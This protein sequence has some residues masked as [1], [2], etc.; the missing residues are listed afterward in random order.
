[1]P[2]SVEGSQQSGTSCSGY[3]FL[4][5]PVV[6][7]G[8]LI[9]SVLSGLLIGTAVLIL[10]IVGSLFNWVVEH[11]VILFSGSFF[12]TVKPAVQTAWTAFRDLG[13]IV[14]IGMFTYTALS[15]ILGIQKFNAKS[16]VAKVLLIAIFI[17]FSLLFTSLVIDA[18]N[19]VATQFYNA[20]GQT[21]QAG[22]TIGN[23]T[24]NANGQV[25]TAAPLGISGLLLSYMGIS[26][27]FDGANLTWRLGQESD[28]GLLAFANGIFVTIVLLGVALV[29]LYG[30]F[31]LVSRAILLIFLMLTSALAFASYL[32]PGLAESGYGWKTWWHSLL[33]SAVLAPLI[34]LFLWAT[35]LVARYMAA[36]SGGGTIGDLLVNPTGGGN[37]GALF[38]YIIILGLLFVSFKVSSSF[39]TSIAG[40]DWA[41]YGPLK[42]LGAASMPARFALRAGSRGT[43]FLGDEAQ[44]KARERVAAKGKADWLSRRLDNVSTA[45]QATRKSDFNAMRALGRTPL[46]GDALMKTA[47]VKK[48]EDIA[49]KMRSREDLVKDLAKASQERGGRLA[50]TQDQINA[51]TSKE[52]QR[53]M[54]NNPEA[55]KQHDQYRATVEAGEKQVAELKQM[56]KETQETFTK[57]VSELSKKFEQAQEAA[58]LA[59]KNDIGAQ[60]KAEQ[61]RLDVERER[62][63]QKEAFNE[64][65]ERISGAQRTV[66]EAKTG[67]AEIN[68]RLKQ[69]AIAKGTLPEHFPKADE[70]GQEDAYDRTGNTFARVFHRVSGTS[71][72]EAMKNDEVTREMRS[73]AEKNRKKKRVQDALSDYIEK[74]EKPSSAPKPASPAP[75]TPAS[76]A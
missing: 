56:Q 10:T 7:T 57:S 21:A 14:I 19:F 46:L 74:E 24:V 60:D 64:Q 39:A 47:G 13:N 44:R 16:H 2:A 45:L 18:S 53:E 51:M 37:I 65:Q 1:M 52:V 58:R 25:Q 15:M 61:A 31:L 71:R 3:S 49:G 76:T 29:L 5:S 69:A 35:L 9:G 70:I 73:T 63:R 20:M 67:I 26:S 11:T 59:P 12:D 75:G 34:M 32:I 40:F 17:N 72:A 41:A 68:E 42:A 22:S 28:S 38:N 4:W 48:M 27:A 36:A 43:G 8:R 55:Q 66:N 50:M 30:A 33:H 54:A 6:C 62:E 23:A